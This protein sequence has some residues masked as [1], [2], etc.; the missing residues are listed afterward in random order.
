MSSQLERTDPLFDEILCITDSKY[1]LGSWYFI[2]LPNGRSVQD[3]TALC[4]MTQANYGHAR[5]LYRHL[6]AFGFSREEAEWHREAKDIRNARILDDPPNSW[7]DLVVSSYL[8]EFAVSLRLK[9]FA[10]A[11]P[12]STLSRLAHKM[13][14]ETSF[15]LIYLEGWLDVASNS[16][17]QQVKSILEQ[18]LPTV[19][20]WVGVGAPSVISDTVHVQGYRAEPDSALATQFLS[21]LAATFPKFPPRSDAAENVAVSTADWRPETRRSGKPGIPVRLHELIRFKEPGLA[22]P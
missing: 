17:G 16:L 8:V 6:S 10:D 12:S 22:V 4:A 9:S 19:L 15:H 3:W 1:V 2:V 7:V 11:S 20:E 13:H 18:R 14:R 21:R 5:A